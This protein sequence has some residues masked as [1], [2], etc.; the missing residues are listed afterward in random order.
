MKKILAILALG[1]SSSVF[2][3]S[4]G[5]EYQ[6]INGVQGSPD[7]KAYE[8]NVKDNFNKN[9]AGDVKFTNTVTDNTNALTTRLE[10]G[11]TAQNTYGAFTPYTR[12]GVGQKFSNTTDFTYYSIEPGVKATVKYFPGLTARVGW[13]FRDAF[14]SANNDTTRTWRAGLDYAVT[15]KDTVGI[16]YDSVRGDSNQNIFKVNYSRGF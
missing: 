10:A 2:A 7:Q 12:L 1:L 9:F 14:D 5:L 11:L 6:N 13:R 15:S 8:L 3:A 4:V 16:G